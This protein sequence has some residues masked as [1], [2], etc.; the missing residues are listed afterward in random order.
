[1]VSA[2]LADLDAQRCDLAEAV[3]F[4]LGRSGARRESLRPLVQHGMAEGII[5]ANID[6][7]C[8]GHPVPCYA[9][10]GEGANGGLFKPVYVFLDENAPRLEIDKRI[11][12]HLTRAMISNLAAAISGNDRNVAGC[13]NVLASPGQTQS[14]D[15]RMLTD[16][17]LIDRASGMVGREL[18]HGLESGP[19]FNA[20]QIVDVH[21][22]RGR[23]AKAPT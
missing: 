18:L 16:P 11:R 15:A 6:A 23:G 12:D 10:V 14:E 3:E 2:V 13:Q 1:M 9:K 4:G 20:A 19:V 8:P 21:V 17:E 7:W 5:Q 22:V